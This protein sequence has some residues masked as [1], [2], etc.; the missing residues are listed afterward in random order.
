MG[1]GLWP[2][3]GGD[4]FTEIMK[5]YTGASSSAPSSPASS[6]AGNMSSLIPVY[7]TQGIQDTGFKLDVLSI[8]IAEIV[9]AFL[10]IV[11]KIIL[12]KLEK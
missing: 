4:K 3:N 6:P 12:N 8:V 5:G 9:F 1:G 2:S 7:I 10:V 11:V